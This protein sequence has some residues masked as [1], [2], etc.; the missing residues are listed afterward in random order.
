MLNG[1]QKLVNMENNKK[2]LIISLT[3]V[4]FLLMSFVVFKIIQD[5]SSCSKNPSSYFIKSI[6]SKGSEYNC[7]CFST[8]QKYISFSFDKDGIQLNKIGG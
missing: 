4:W 2:I 1:I 6:N 8:N 7:N 5:N 3:I